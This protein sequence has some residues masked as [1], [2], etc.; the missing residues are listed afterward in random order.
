M[1]RDSALAAPKH[2]GSSS[3]PIT[4][5]THLGMPDCLAQRLTIAKKNIWKSPVT[6]EG[7]EGEGRNSANFARIGKLKRNGCRRLKFF[8]L[9]RPI[10][11]RKSLDAV[12]VTNVQCRH[13]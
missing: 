12:E 11:D 3:R 5:L 10:L 1:T 2:A 7:S 8:R 13:D 9:L 4:N 6:G